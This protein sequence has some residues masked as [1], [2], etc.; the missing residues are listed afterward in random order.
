MKE[1]FILGL[2]LCGITNSFWG[3]PFLLS[4]FLGGRRGAFYGTTSFLL[5]SFTSY[6]VILAFLLYWGERIIGAIPSLE[7]L[8]ALLISIFSLLCGFFLILSALTM[9]IIL[10]KITREYLLNGWV[11][12]LFGFLVGLYL[13]KSIEGAGIYFNNLF[14]SDKAKFVL[15]SFIFSFGT[16]LSPLY[17]LTPFFRFFRRKV[18]TVG[19]VRFW[20]ALAGVVFLLTGAAFLFLR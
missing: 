1:A 17:F 9:N 8:F 16:F 20:D 2:S 13:G 14:P 6:I 5:G 3:V 11:I 15:A 7:N 18:V 12:Y 19:E 10:E 4:F